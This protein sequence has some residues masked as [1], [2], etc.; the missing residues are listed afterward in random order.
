MARVLSKE[1]KFNSAYFL[2]NKM[3][4]LCLLEFPWGNEVNSKG[5]HA[6]FL[7]IKQVMY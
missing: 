3:S 2:H 4:Y 5:R 6:S 1:M 7:E